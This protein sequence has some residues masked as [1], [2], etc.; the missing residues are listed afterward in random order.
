MAYKPMRAD[1]V[2]IHRKHR[3]SLSL[4]SLFKILVSALQL[5]EVKE[6]LDVHVK[7]H[8]GPSED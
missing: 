3:S 4:F 2:E 5:Q 7:T 1:T 8:L 6:N